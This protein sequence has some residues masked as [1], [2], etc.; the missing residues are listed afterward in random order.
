MLSYTCHFGVNGFW[1]F[2][3]SSIFWVEEKGTE[4]KGRER[5]EEEGKEEEESEMAAN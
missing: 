3:L 5:R 4:G 1:G 2:R